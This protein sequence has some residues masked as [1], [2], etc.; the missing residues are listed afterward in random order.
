MCS[1]VVVAQD[2]F[3]FGALSQ[4]KVNTLTPSVGIFSLFHLG[5][6]FDE[7][8][9]SAWVNTDSI[10]GG[11]AGGGTL[12]KL[13]HPIWLGWELSAEY[14]FHQ[15]EEVWFLGFGPVLEFQVLPHRLHLFAKLPLGWEHTRHHELFGWSVITGFALVVWH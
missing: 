2:E 13:Y 15:K 4:L 1:R 7:I 10:I 14:E 5:G 3:V 6:E 12:H 11:G 8:H 9:A